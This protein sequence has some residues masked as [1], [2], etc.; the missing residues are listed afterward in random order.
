MHYFSAWSQRARERL[1]GSS[2][3]DW[4]SFLENSPTMP[5]RPIFLAFLRGRIV[6]YI[7]SR[8]LFDAAFIV[9]LALMAAMVFVSTRLT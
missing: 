6:A 7:R 4:S 8:L 3:E 2:L 1:A 9:L 5:M